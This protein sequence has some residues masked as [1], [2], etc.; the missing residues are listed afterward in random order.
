MGDAGDI[1]ITANQVW[2]DGQGSSQSFTGISSS[3]LEGLG[4]GGDIV[5]TVAD[6][7]SIV[8]KGQITAGTLDTGDAGQVIVN[9]GH[10]LING[11][12]VGAGIFSSTQGSGAGRG[13][14]ITVADTILLLRGGQIHASTWGTGDAGQVTVTA[15]QIFIDGQGQGATLVTGIGS[16]AEEGSTGVIGH[17]VVDANTLHLLNGGKITVASKA[18]DPADARSLTDEEIPNIRIT[19][20]DLALSGGSAI[21]SAAFGNMPAGAINLHIDKRLTLDHSTISTEANRGAGGSITMDGGDL[22]LRDSQITT[23]VLGERGDGG[24]ITLTPQALVL[25][26]GFI[27]ANTAAVNAKGGDIHVAASAFISPADQELRIGGQER[28]TFQ[29]G[30]NVIQA[31]APDGVS[32][33]VQVTNPDLSLSSSLVTLN[34]SYL[35]ATAQLS[36]RCGGQFAEERSRFIIQGRG[37]LPPDPGDAQAVNAGRC[38]AATDSLPRTTAPEPLTTAMTGFG[39]R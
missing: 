7:L 24:D 26:G 21:T 14:E 17:I 31:A 30:V 37:S 4:T 35:D 12:G 34:T 28:E 13:V 2:I 3:V 20:R 11:Q 22:L 6:T 10:L 29:P 25:D 27:Q 36:S 38:R 8:N 5:L 19:A 39:D 15:P 32:G 18:I 1:T 23:S 9:A 33:A 16:S